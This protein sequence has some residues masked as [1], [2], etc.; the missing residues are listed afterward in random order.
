MLGDFMVYFLVAGVVVV[1]EI[2]GTVEGEN[3]LR[4]LGTN[5]SKTKEEKKATVSTYTRIQ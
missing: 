2:L 5:L 4:K 1:M 3:I